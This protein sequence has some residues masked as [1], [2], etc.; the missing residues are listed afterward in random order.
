MLVL[1]F[2]GKINNIHS[3]V[4]REL[5]SIQGKQIQ[6]GSDVKG[7]SIQQN[8]TPI[9]EKSE[10]LKSGGS[11]ISKLKS[12]RRRISI[13]NLNKSIRSLLSLLKKSI[14]HNTT[15]S[16]SPA[17]KTLKTLPSSG[18][19]KDQ[20]ASSLQESGKDQT[21]VEKT[22]TKIQSE[23]AQNGSSI[24]NNVD[25]QGKLDE[26]VANGVRYFQGVF[27]VED[28]A[29]A[30]LLAKISVY[31]G[32]NP[33]TTCA[34]FDGYSNKKL[35]VLLSLHDQHPDLSYDE[36]KAKCDAMPNLV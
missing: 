32:S 11:L 35:E 4:I 15:T 18:L 30:V 28:K 29:R 21:V 9:L 25:E 31:V 13:S 24:E 6:K 23:V 36:L 33:E 1:K 17:E 14:L 22:Q 2:V 12:F 10:T 5:Q 26:N 16:Q 34:R 19:I 8:S 20:K 27:G 7:R 3:S